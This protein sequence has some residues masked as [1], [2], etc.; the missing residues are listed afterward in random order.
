MIRVAIIGRPNVGKSTLFNRMTHSRSAIVSDI[1]GTTRDMRERFVSASGG[2]QFLLM[3]T[4]GLGESRG[5]TLEARMTKAALAGAE[6]ADLVLFV[7]DVRSS[8]TPE[9]AKFAGM[10][11]KYGKRVILVAN[12]AEDKRSLS[13]AIGDLFALGFGE[14]VAVSAEHGQGVSA[15]AD[16]IEARIR[17]AARP[18][19]NVAPDDGICPAHLEEIIEIEEDAQNDEPPDMKVR[20]AVVGRPNAGK[21]TLVNALLGKER[22]LTGIEAGLTRDAVDSDFTYKGRE[23]TIVDTA[24][25]RKKNK[26]HEEIEQMSTARSIGAIKKSDVVI[27]V[28]DAS[29]GLDGQDVA[30]AEVAASE[31]KGVVFAMNKGDLLDDRK[32]VLQAARDRLETSFAQVKEIPSVIISAARGAGTGALMAAAFELYDIRNQRA[33]TG[34]L[35]RW[36]EKATAKNPPP[37]SRLKRPISL[38]YITQSA[39][40]PP[41]FTLFTGNAGNLPESYR[42]YLLNSLCEEFGFGKVPVRLKVKASKNPYKENK[43]K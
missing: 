25:L 13:A 22:M 20:L 29:A 26:V 37:L 15:L 5:G 2:T 18:S 8:V 14:P 32:A 28:V 6:A 31:G 34:L 39:L 38:K 23:V 11:R 1:A 17:E 41:T 24:G 4:A 36:L 27:V 35:N 7:V 12:K 19:D 42:R 3:D 10:L 33:T 16:A 9:D 43:P 40:R 30:I 21:S